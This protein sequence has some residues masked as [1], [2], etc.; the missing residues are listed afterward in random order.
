MDHVV[1]VVVVSM[2]KFHQTRDPART[3]GENLAMCGHMSFCIHKEPG[4]G[5]RSRNRV[6][7][8]SK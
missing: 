2:N 4:A 7:H 8:E 1:E 5:L 3:E 6:I